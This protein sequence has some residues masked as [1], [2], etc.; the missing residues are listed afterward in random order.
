VKEPA[1]IERLIKTKWYSYF[2]DLESLG[3][4]P[5]AIFQPDDIRKS[6][7]ESDYSGWKSGRVA[8]SRGNGS[9]GII[10]QVKG[11][12]SWVRRNTQEPWTDPDI[13]PSRRPGPDDV[14][15]GENDWNGWW[16]GDGGGD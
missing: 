14:P 13:I 16:G 3:I 1:E 15:G 7:A 2:Q 11:K 6:T 12:T 5:R 9:A 4:D 10:D 8:G